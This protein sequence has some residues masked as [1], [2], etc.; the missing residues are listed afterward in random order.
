MYVY[1]AAIRYEN[2]TSFLSFV[3]FMYKAKI[4]KMY[5]RLNSC[6]VIAA[7]RRATCIYLHTITGISWDSE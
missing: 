6:I 3:Y 4:I 1:V 7:P 2:M 5:E